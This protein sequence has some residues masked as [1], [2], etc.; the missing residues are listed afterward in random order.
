MF[1]TIRRVVDRH[2]HGRGEYAHL[3]A[4]YTGEEVMALD[5]ET[6]GLDPRT[7]GLVSVAAVPVRDDRVISSEA[8]DLHL[9]RPAGLSAESIRIHRLRRMDLH[10]GL[11]LDDALAQLLAFVGNRPLLG[12]CIDFDMAVINRHLRPR[13]GFELPNATIELSS[14]YQRHLRR[15]QPE[16][17]PDLRFE[18]IARALKVPE[19]GRHSAKGD[20]TTS[21]LM[22]LRLKKLG[23]GNGLH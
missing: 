11:A 17:T 16:I 5:C 12:W 8:L 13:Y 4:P 21:A 23:A 22:Y 9:R 2:R 20:A 14:L 7:A 18:A 15:T 6:T 1:R 10:D 3:F 19:L